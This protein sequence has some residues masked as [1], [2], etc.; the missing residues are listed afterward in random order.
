MKI[1][2]LVFHVI[3]TNGTPEP[4]NL[5]L[6]SLGERTK[7]AFSYGFIGEWSARALF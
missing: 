4:V 7:K 3:V 1:A 6:F 5:E 2:R